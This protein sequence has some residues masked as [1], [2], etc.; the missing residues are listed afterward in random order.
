M[1]GRLSSRSAAL[2]TNSLKSTDNFFNSSSRTSH[3]YGYGYGEEYQGGDGDYEYEEEDGSEYWGA[4][5]SLDASRFGV[6]I[7]Y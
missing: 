5:F 2:I 4:S 7:F 3:M 6:M 1:N